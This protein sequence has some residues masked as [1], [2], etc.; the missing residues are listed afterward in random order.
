MSCLSETIV[1]PLLRPMSKVVRQM[2]DHG[3]PI[4]SVA[5]P[6]SL[7]VFAGR[8]EAWQEEAGGHFSVERFDGGLFFVVPMAL[9]ALNLEGRESERYVRFERQDADTGEPGSPWRVTTR[10]PG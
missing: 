8:D 10:A 6:M 2:T 4:S 9:L 7:H 5:L 1:F 3:V